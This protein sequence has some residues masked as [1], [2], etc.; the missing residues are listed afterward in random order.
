MTDDAGNGGTKQL[1]DRHF[2]DVPAPLPIDFGAL[3]HMG[4][5]RKNNE[6]HYAV[7]RR[8][9]GREVVLTNLPAGELKHA[10][11][12]AWV[13]TVADGMGGGAFGEVASL[14][15]LRSGWDLTSGEFKWHFNLGPQDELREAEAVIQLKGKLIH[16]ALL[17]AAEEQPE[18]KGMG[19][20]I[21]SVIVTGNEGVV[22]HAGDSRVYLLRSGKLHRLTRDH[23]L[24]EFHKDTG[25]IELEAESSNHLRSVLVN[26]LGGNEKNVHIETSRVRF[27]PGDRLMLCTDGLNDMVREPEIADV[28]RAADDPQAAADALVKQALSNG[29]RDN[30]TVVVARI[31][32]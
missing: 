11:Q 32:A 14:M 28:L 13:M 8:Y 2:G 6:D 30:V 3:S 20:T 22:A 16:R 10:V 17:K 18:L 7:V 19:T 24:A 21:A 9:R 1:R 31:R 4:H 5:V 23:T 29:G 25:Q 27:L 26:C 15:A 12:E